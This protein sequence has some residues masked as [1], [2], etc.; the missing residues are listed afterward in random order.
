MLLAAV[1]KYV[2]GSNFPSI[3]ALRG[4][5]NRV[6]FKKQKSKKKCIQLVSRKG[7]PEILL[8]S[9]SKLT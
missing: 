5:S 1:S 7:H 9:D 8:Q 3:T 2:N 4:V 6:F